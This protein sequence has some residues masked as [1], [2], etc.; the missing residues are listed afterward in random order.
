VAV[1]VVYGVLRLIVSRRLSNLWRSILRSLEEQHPAWTPRSPGR[2][3]TWRAV[4]L[5]PRSLPDDPGLRALA[6]TYR[7]LSGA[8]ILLILAA[9]SAVAGCYLILGPKAR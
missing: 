2:Y 6:R 8:T 4:M 9:I 3:G 7:L 1:L 5:R